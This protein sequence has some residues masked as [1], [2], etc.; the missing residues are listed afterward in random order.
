MYT[1]QASG[2]SLVHLPFV[3]SEGGCSFKQLLRGAQHKQWSP[4][5]LS[6]PVALFCPMRRK[7][8][9]DAPWSSSIPLL[10]VNK[11]KSFV[12]SSKVPTTNVGCLFAGSWSYFSRQTAVN[13]AITLS[14]S[15]PN[16]Y[17]AHSSLNSTAWWQTTFFSCIPFKLEYHVS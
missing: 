14:C 2:T 1:K 5:T 15:E 7:E 16:I 9:A 10:L 17:N 6:E 3:S 12:L 8:V 4:C 13:T 11:H